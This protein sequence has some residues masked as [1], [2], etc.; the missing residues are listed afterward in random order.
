MYSCTISGMSRE[1]M[2]MDG[3][4]SAKYQIWEYKDITVI[5]G[6]V[7]KSLDDKFSNSS[8]LHLRDLSKKRDF[9]LGEMQWLVLESFLERE[10]ASL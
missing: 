7:L 1:M 6:K 3:Q 10:R 9:H 5:F 2:K 4:G 8:L